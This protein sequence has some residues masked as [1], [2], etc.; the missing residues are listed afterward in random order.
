ME[1][2]EKEIK[3]KTNKWR[4]WLW[5]LLIPAQWGLCELIAWGALMLDLQ[6]INPDAHGT[7]IPMYGF[8]AAMIIP[9]IKVALIII[10][11]SFTIMT[12]VMYKK[13]HPKEKVGSGVDEL[14]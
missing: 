13:Y 12:Y 8:M 3:K 1:K 10:S 6:S 7:P 14:R 4:G 11:I 5:L 9:G 2:N